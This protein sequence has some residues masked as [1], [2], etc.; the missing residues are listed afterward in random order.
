MPTL[1]FP[2]FDG[3]YPERSEG[4][5]ALAPRSALD[6]LRGAELYALTIE[7]DS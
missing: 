3:F 6:N 7:I 1:A 5:G 2:L 4:L